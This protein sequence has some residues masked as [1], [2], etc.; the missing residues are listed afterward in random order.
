MST[1]AA[2]A[3]RPRSTTPSIIERT[4][5][6]AV[7]VAEHARRTDE[8]AVF[9]VEALTAMRESGLLGLVVPVEYGGLGGT[10]ADLL[11]VAI[12]L[13]R[14]DMSAAMIL[15][16]HCQ[17][18]AAIVKYA[19]EPLRRGLLRRIAAGEVY[20]ASVT[21]EA[22]KGGHLLSA[23]A[24][25]V[26]D[27]GSLVIDRFA[28]IVTGGAHADGFLMTMRSPN[29]A[30]PSEVSLIYAD[31]DQVNVTASG[32]WQPLGM[33]ASH[34]GAL[35]LKGQVPEGNVVGEHG[36]FARIAQDVF[37]PYAHLG[38]AACWLGTACGGLSRVVDLIRSPAERKRFDTGSELLLSR[39]ARSR[40]RIDT[41]HALLR[42]TERTIAPLSDLSAPRHQL[43]LNALKITASEQ[44]YAAVND[45]VEALGLRHGYLKDSPSMLE[46]AL[47]DL[48][49]ASMN[50]SN[51]RLLLA[52]GRLVLLDKGVT[53]A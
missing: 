49:S 19:H 16:M 41:V 22:G 2:T 45:L 47:R 18:A 24:G 51:D 12:R 46:K 15:T 4:E 20:L 8:E 52:D 29:A 13:G 43:Q 26:A 42:H 32:E 6:V 31:R 28:P 14:A 33:R 7:T 34:S 48:R 9:P 1:P 11:D 53:L 35:T 37:A 23:E 50:Y 36:T 39:L 25:L 3:Q 30:S 38:W 40:Q 21:T 44:C 27:E 10:L 17:Q 5:R